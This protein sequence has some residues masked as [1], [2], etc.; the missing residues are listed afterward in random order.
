MCLDEY[1]AMAI[2]RQRLEEARQFAETELLVAALTPPLRVRIGRTLV[3]LGRRLGADA[4]RH[5][6]PSLG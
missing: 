5:V 6:Q 4:P 1:G 3:A 2:V